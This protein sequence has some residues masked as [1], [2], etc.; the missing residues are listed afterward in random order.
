MQW[1]N[2]IIIHILQFQNQSQS[3]EVQSTES[4]NQGTWLQGLH[5]LV[6]L[7]ASVLCASRNA[8]SCPSQVSQIPYSSHRLDCCPSSLSHWMIGVA[9]HHSL[10]CTRHVWV[11]SIDVFLTACPTLRT[12]LCPEEGWMEN[13]TREKQLQGPKQRRLRRV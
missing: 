2:C 10:V 6:P 1:K 3:G 11:H 7:T 12:S 5:S 13:Q 9:P 4:N 8:I